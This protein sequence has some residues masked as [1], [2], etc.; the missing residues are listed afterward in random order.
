MRARSGR[1]FP[2]LR[3]SGK[4]DIVKIVNELCLSDAFDA[5]SDLVGS[6]NTDNLI[7]GVNDA[8][9][10]LNGI[11]IVN[12]A[13]NLAEETLGEMESGAEAAA[14]SAAFTAV[15]FLLQ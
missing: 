1:S 10:S 8:I 4:R 11:D 15:L 3:I 2:T 14:A 13:V 6:I 5:A 12:E 7:D 9:D